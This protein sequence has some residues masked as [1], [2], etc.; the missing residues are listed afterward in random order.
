MR[1]NN[2]SLQNKNLRI[3]YNFSKEINQKLEIIQELLSNKKVI[4]GFSGGVDST[5]LAFLSSKFA[6]ET[7]LVT[8]ENEL[9]TE[10]ELEE[11]KKIKEILGLP[12]RIIHINQ[13]KDSNFIKNDS[14]R[15][16]Y[17]KKTILSYLEEIKVK[18]G[19]DI[20][21]EG[22]NY[23]DLTEPRPGYN[24]V[25]EKNAIS[26]F[27]ESHL[28][29]AEIREISKVIGLPTWNKVPTPCT[30]SRFL[31][32]TPITRQSI[33]RIQEAEKF[34]KRRFGFEII[35]VRYDGKKAIIQALR[36]DLP[37]I[38]DPS[39]KKIILKNLKEL[40]FEKVIISDK[41]YTRP[42]QG[43]M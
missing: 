40:G 16:Y 5:L 43:I 6:K 38:T 23:S 10:E 17:C 41:P 13:L 28:T 34:L 22:T 30:A 24:A 1:Q 21:L 31:T 42:S 27:V 15:C 8:V 12:L 36:K 37:V 4:I 2:F 18:E 3:N 33:K 35:R 11:L 9:I 29:K 39:N 25:K 20:I 7:L 19:Y 26:P 32:G 14:N